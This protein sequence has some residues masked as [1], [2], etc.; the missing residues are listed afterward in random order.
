MPKSRVTS[1]SLAD[2]LCV[3]SDVNMEVWLSS[4]SMIRR[5]AEVPPLKRHLETLFPQVWLWLDERLK[6][7]TARPRR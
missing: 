5:T 2:V 6:I 7:A 3:G 1:T 4:Q